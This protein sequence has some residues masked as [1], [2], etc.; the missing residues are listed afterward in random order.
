MKRSTVL[1]IGLALLMAMAATQAPAQEVNPEVQKLADQWTQAYN[2]HNRAALSE[3]YKEDAYLMMH[4]SRTVKGR[5]AIGDFWVQDFREGNPITTLTVTH[6]IEGV[7]MIL[8]HGDY[9]VI[10]REDGLLLGQGRFAQIW[11]NGDDGEWRID[12]D[13]WNEPLNPYGSR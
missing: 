5:Q 10:N 13:L 6:A 3:L 11:M 8:V 9:Q 7:D 1:S 2:A 12:R 4:G